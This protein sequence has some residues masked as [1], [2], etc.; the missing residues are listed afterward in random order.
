MNLLRLGRWSMA[1]RGPKPEHTSMI[2]V[3]PQ[4]IECRGTPRQRGRQYGEQCR[5]AIF[6]NAERQAFDSHM[7]SARKLLAELPDYLRRIA[8]EVLEEMEGIA[9]AS[10]LPLPRV[11]RLNV[12]QSTDAQWQ[13]CTSMALADGPEGPV[14]GKN[15]D[16][17]STEEARHCFVLRKVYPTS[18]VPLVQVV[19]AGALSGLDAMN[20]E[21]LATGHNSVGSTLP[22]RGPRLD[23]RLR[24]YQLMSRCRTVPELLK[25]LAGGP[26]L[27]GK[28]H[29]IVAVDRAG[30]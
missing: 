29:N 16:S 21:G 25:G 19:H 28:G 18:G 26:P 6:W 1:G 2:L 24:T 5:E 20:A 9:E 7:Q 30:Q 17:G 11:L 13:Q 14:L 8:P 10:G 12:N 3:Q 22:R 23:I 4:P 27:T 15:N